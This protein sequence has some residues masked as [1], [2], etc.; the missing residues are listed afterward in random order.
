MPALSAAQLV[1]LSC[2][3]QRDDGA[4]D[5][6]QSR[7]GGAAKTVASLL[8]R[9]LLAEIESRPG[10]PVWRRSDTDEAL[11][12]VITT[13][14]KLLIGIDEEA[15]G[16]EAR[17]VQPATAGA[18]ANLESPAQQD[19]EIAPTL[20]EAPSFSSE[21]SPRETGATAVASSLLETTATADMAVLQSPP[22]R[23]GTKRA[24]VIAMLSEG[25]G[26]SLAEIIDA[27][28]W[29]P[30]TTRAALTVLRHQ[31]YI[32]ERFCDDEQKTRYRIVVARASA[33]RPA[34]A[35]NPAHEAAEA[36]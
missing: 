16:E 18:E 4:V 36:V 33:D 2:A 26:A 14:G 25:H 6:A 10:M 32:I 23:S 24:L 1:M 21:M 19:S 30:H 17:G 11:S 7:R 15:E 9:N 28:N 13:A 8:L 5:P 12:L 35:E 3:S 27:T 20:D 34:V 22:A 29:L 31:G